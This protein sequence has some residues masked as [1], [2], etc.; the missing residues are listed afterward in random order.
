MGVGWG[1]GMGL[2]TSGDDP[3]TP[4]LGLVS[5]R[6]GTNIH[7]VMLPQTPSANESGFYVPQIGVGVSYTLS[8]H[9]S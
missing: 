1:V 5:D 8:I 4:L 9:G 3:I 2:T 6:F 7:G